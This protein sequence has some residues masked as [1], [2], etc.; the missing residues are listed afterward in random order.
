MMY[1]LTGQ[2]V[3]RVMIGH[4]M[5]NE[6]PAVGTMLFCFTNSRQLP[7]CLTPVTGRSHVFMH[8][9]LRRSSRLRRQRRRQIEIVAR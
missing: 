3:G 2:L 7:T 1:K 8:G 4:G 5:T 6:T 9:Q